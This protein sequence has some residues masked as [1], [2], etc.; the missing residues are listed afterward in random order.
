MANHQ[1]NSRC[2]PRLVAIVVGGI[3]ALAITVPALSQQTEIYDLLIVNGRLIDGTGNAW[4]YADVGIHDDR[5]ERITPRGG[6]ATVAAKETI[7]A[8]GMVVAPGFID[9]QSHSR[10]QFLA[11]D[12]RV[13]SNFV[14]QAMRDEDI[15]IY[16]DG[17]I[18]INTASREAHRTHRMVGTQL[19]TG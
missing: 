5:I 10:S 18:N 4:I 13:I 17:K 7:D 2:L 11:G 14:L 12:G 1:Q 8:M 16:G 19:V 3:V 6:L 9:I 15:T